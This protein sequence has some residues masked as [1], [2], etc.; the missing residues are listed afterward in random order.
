MVFSFR[1]RTHSPEDVK[2]E[3]SNGAEDKRMADE[4]PEG[5]NKNSLSP[6]SGRHDNDEM[7]HP[8]TSQ[9]QDY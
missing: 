3:T 7:F 9:V 2:R 1:S 5:E 6:Q 4:H 8:T